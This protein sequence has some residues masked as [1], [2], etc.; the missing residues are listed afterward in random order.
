MLIFNS[1]I[2]HKT[3]GKFMK[4]LTFAAIINNSQE[5]FKT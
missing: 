1:L 5:Y 2:Y 3:I 4:I